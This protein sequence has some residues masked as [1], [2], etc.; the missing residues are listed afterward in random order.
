MSALGASG[1]LVGTVVTVDAPEVAEALVG[2]GLSW[3]LVD[4][5]HAPTMGGGEV[6]RILQ[7]VHGRCRTV[8]RVPANDPTWIGVALDTGCDGVLIPRVAGPDDA[9]RAVRAAKYPLAGRRGVGAT[10]A[11]GYGV[12]F[13]DYLQH[14]NDTTAV[15][16]QVQDEAAVDRIDAVIA[17]THVAGVFIEP[18]DLSGSMG[19][20]GALGHPA[21]IAAIDHVRDRCRTAQVPLGIFTPDPTVAAQQIAKGVNMLAVGTDMTLLTGAVRTGLAHLLGRPDWGPSPDQPV[22]DLGC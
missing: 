16:V 17:V 1:P 20:P 14:A 7:A 13:D 15:I 3:L 11:H 5:E 8:V 10:R 22:G 18:Y 6:Q 2:C 19:W 4:M 21:V 12:R 9:A